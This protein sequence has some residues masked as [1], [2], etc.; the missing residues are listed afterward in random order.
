M[1]K[2]CTNRYKNH[3]VYE[4]VLNNLYNNCMNSFV[5][6]CTKISE[7]KRNQVGISTRDQ[8]GSQ[9]SQRDQYGLQSSQR[10]AI[11]HPTASISG[12]FIYIPCNKITIRKMRLYKF[13]R[14]TYSH[15][16]GRQQRWQRRGQA[17]T[18]AAD[19][20]RGS[21]GGRQQSTRKQQQ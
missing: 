5:R 7:K 18:A 14:V 8:Y 20:N 6:I 12:H 11:H 15:P 2:K 17:R 9:S 21:S 1:Y 10:H 19:G 13:I 16:A 3:T 4:F